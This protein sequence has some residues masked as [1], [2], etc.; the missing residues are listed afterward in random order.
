VRTI[1]TDDYSSFE[2]NSCGTTLDKDATNP[3]TH[4]VNEHQENDQPTSPLTI[5]DHQDNQSAQ[6]LSVDRLVKYEQNQIAD[7]NMNIAAIYER[8][9]SLELPDSKAKPEFIDL[10]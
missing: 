8:I 2:L 7:I 9:A 5:G 6:E 3:S 10:L 1:Q 4:E